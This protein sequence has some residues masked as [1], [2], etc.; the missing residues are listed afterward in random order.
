L[1]LRPPE[2]HSGAIDFS[3]FSRLEIILDNPCKISILSA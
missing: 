2:P 1:N 3:G